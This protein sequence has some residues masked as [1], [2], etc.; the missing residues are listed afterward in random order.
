MYV[1]LLPPQSDFG[2]RRAGDV[3]GA[4]R[5]PSNQETGPRGRRGKATPNEK[6]IGNRLNDHFGISVDWM[7]TDR[8][9][10]GRGQWPRRPAGT[11]ALHTVGVRFNLSGS[12]IFPKTLQN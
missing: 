3:R 8:Q 12:S 1:F 6:A 7:G 10:K 9:K 5:P 11:W 4:D 2:A